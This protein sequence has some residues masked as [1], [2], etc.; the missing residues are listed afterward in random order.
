MNLL[1]RRI[2]AKVLAY[3]KS[4]FNPNLG[5][6]LGV[7]FEVGSKITTPPHPP[8]PPRPSPLV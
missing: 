7:C 6:F 2:A 8:T 1:W 3:R 4:N 5:G